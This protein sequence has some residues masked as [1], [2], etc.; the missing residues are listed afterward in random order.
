MYA[1][2]NKL[3]IYNVQSN[4]PPTTLTSP[5]LASDTSISVASTSEFTVFEGMAVSASNPGYVKVEDEIIKYESVGTG[6][7]LTITRGIDSTIVL[8]HDTLSTQ[9]YKYELSGVSLR[10]INTTHDISDTG[11][12]IDSYYIQF[13]RTNFDSYA[14]NRSTDGSLTSAPQLSF[15]SE[16]TSGGSGVSATENIQYD[17]ITPQVVGIVPGSSTEITAQIRSVSGTSVDG[18]EV[19]FIDQGYENVE[20]GVANKLTSTRIV[21]SHVNEETY[22]NGTLLANR[23]NSLLMKVNLSTTDDNLSPMIFWRNSAVQ[24]LSSRLNKPVSNYITDNSANSIID[25]PHAAVYVSNTV[26]LSQPA[27]SLKVIVSAY[28]HASAD[29]RVLYSLIRPDSSEVEQSFELFPGYNNLTVDGNQDGYP[30]VI[31]PSNNSGLPDV[32]VPASLDNQFLEY[33]FTANN[34][35]DFT[36]Y[37]IKIVMSGTNQAYAPRFKDLRSIAI[38]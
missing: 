25:D 9:V 10:R 22:L 20:I 21:C 1:P 11:N 3:N 7:L 28:R 31:N 2:N 15:N 34:L 30:D 24:L 27:T 36:G 32:F 35:G 14:T 23:T 5:L 13:D 17:T 8:D 19:S 29:F 33:D 12:D 26:R 16:T 37:T 18:T 6:Q 4:V 38:R